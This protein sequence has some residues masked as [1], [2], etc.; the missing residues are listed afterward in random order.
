M[1]DLGTKI[2]HPA[3]G[4]LLLIRAD[5][6][7]RECLKIFGAHFGGSSNSSYC[8]SPLLNL[9]F[10]K[11]GPDRVKR[12]TVPYLTGEICEHFVGVWTNFLAFHRV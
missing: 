7:P 4:G 5:Y 10:T 9:L 8:R 2:Y 6:L 12:S 3:V 1:C 11:C